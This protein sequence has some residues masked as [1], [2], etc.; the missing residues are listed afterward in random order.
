MYNY[1][2]LKRKAL[3]PE[4]TQY[5]IDSL[6]GWFNRY[7]DPFWNGE[8]WTIDSSYDMWPIYEY[9]EEYDVYTTVGYEI[10]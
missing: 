1:E 10:R 8:C 2:E 3:A 6:G 5:D 7:G 4:A 9:D